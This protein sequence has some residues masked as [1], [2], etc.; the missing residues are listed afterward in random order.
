[1]TPQ[2]KSSETRIMSN[3]IKPGG[4]RKADL[5]GAFSLALIA[6]SLSGC[7][8][9]YAN[10][11][12]I[13]Y[14]DYHERHPIVLA[15]APTVVNVYPVGVGLDPQSAASVKS[16]AQRYREFGSGEIVILAP[17]GSRAAGANVVAEIRKELYANGL[18]GYVAVGSYSARDK[19][20]GSPYRLAF[21]GL[22]AKVPSRC[23]QWPS[24]LASGTS[25]EGW[26]NE[27][28]EN[29][30]CATQSVLAAQVDDPRD[31][32]HAR[33]LGPADEEMRLRAIGNVRK[34]VDPGTDWKTTITA[35][36]AVG[37]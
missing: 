33:A 35:I 26:K 30:G 36:G 14:R 19:T 7:G 6:A 9:D 21:Q 20:L 37:N 2:L 27:S 28:Y 4:L 22:K 5:F 29:F 17:E 25:V 16:F 12:T 10:P 32:A 23:G 1:M 11:D 8:V 18:R 34:G 15:Q 13:A 24:D 31:F 3:A